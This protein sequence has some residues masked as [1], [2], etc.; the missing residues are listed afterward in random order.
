MVLFGVKDSSWAERKKGLENWLK[1]PKKTCGS[2]WTWPTCTLACARSSSTMPCSRCSS[3]SPTWS[4][5]S[6]WPPWTSSYGIVD[7]LSYSISLKDPLNLLENNKLQLFIFEWWYRY[8]YCMDAFHTMCLPCLH[9]KGANRSFKPD[10]SVGRD[11]DPHPYFAWTRSPLRLRWERKSDLWLWVMTFPKLQDFFF[12]WGKIC[13]GLTRIGR[14]D[15]GVRKFAF[16]SR[17]LR[18]GGHSKHTKMF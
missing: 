10:I 16:V 18:R 3:V 8:P 1:A 15:S 6:L 13:S 11:P 9:R 7:R 12:S 17:L 14:T 4:T 5:C 2:A